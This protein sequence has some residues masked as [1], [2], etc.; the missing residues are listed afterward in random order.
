[1]GQLDEVMVLSVLW[2]RD[3]AT[4]EE[5]ALTMQRK[6][7]YAQRVLGEMD[8]KLP[9][10]VEG[11]AYRLSSPVR[12]DIQAIFQSDQLSLDWSI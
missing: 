10:E 11:Y 9:L 5:L 3:S 12:Q 8:K 2:R 4:L 6:P 7:E 1:M